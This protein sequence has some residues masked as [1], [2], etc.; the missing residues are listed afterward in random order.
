MAGIGFGLGGFASAFQQ[1]MRDNSLADYR[2]QELKLQ[3]QAQKNAEQRFQT[4]R[5]DQIRS[6]AMKNIAE[7]I[8]SIKIAHPEIGNDQISKQFMPWVEQVAGLTQKSGLDPATVY[9][10]FATALAR[11]PKTQTAAAMTAATTEPKV[12]KMTSAS[13]DQSIAIVDPYKKTV[14]YPGGQPDTSVPSPREGLEPGEIDTNFRDALAKRAGLTSEELDVAGR[15]WAAGNPTAVQNLGRSRGGEAQKA[16]RAWGTHTL[17]R[18]EGLSAKTAAEVLANNVI[19]FS[20]MKAGAASLARREAQVIGASETAM[21]T[22]PRVTEASDAVDRTKYS[23]INAIILAGKRRTGDENVIRFG[24]A[25]NTF[26]NN[27][28][29]AVGAGSATL[30]DTARAEAT[31]NLQLAWSNGQIH[32]AIDQMLNKELPS[33]VTGAK[34]G[35]REFLKQ[36]G[37]AVPPGGSGGGGGGGKGGPSSMSDDELKKKL[38]IGPRSES[39]PGNKVA[40]DATERQGFQRR[41]DNA[42]SDKDILKIRKELEKRGIDPE[43]IPALRMG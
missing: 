28:A 23:D 1:G 15:S 40:M 7:G 36:R 2:Q 22:A 35:M 18:E 3:E 33:E 12:E 5:I 21:Q 43:T 27:Y 11:P 17:M 32:A 42:E 30:T 13:G 19:E 39:S 25:V 8:E 6:D 26:I 34:L 31:A 37:Y 16:I 38:G 10:Q 29:R 4:T 24:I 41:I 14:D 20:G 9:S